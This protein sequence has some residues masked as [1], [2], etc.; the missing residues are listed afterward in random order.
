M[1]LAFYSHSVDGTKQS[2]SKPKTSQPHAAAKHMPSSKQA[3]PKASKLDEASFT[4]KTQLPYSKRKRPK[5]INHGNK[6]VKKSRIGEDTWGGIVAVERPVVLTEWSN[7]R[8]FPVD[9][10]WQHEVC[11]LLNL[12]F[13]QPVDRE[14]GGGDI[15]LTLPDMTHLKRIS[16]DGNCLFRAMSFIIT[17]SETQHFEV[18]SA[19]IAHMFAN[20]ELLTGYGADGH[21]NYLAYYHGGYS[22]VE[23]YL[24]RTRKAMS[25]AWGTDFEMTLLAHLLDT[26]VYSYKAGQFWIAC[27]PKGIDHSLPE[28]VNKKSMYI[29]YTVHG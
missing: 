24:A 14:S 23:N 15:I 1:Y 2:K 10:E 11:S 16:G 4:R 19:I 12:R 28:N 7:Y 5:V 29:Y 9:E 6:C 25:G 8:Y 27:F 18:R 13:I 22:S 26:V 3:F 17:G 20:R 21:Q